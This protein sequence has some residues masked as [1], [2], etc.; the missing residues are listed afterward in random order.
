M[1]A[2]SGRCS[3]TAR[4]GGKVIARGSR[5]VRRGRATSVRVR[6]TRAGRARVRR[7]RAGRITLTIKAP[8]GGTQ[9]LR[10][11]LRR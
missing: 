3:V 5:R 10:I 8:G 9:R 1:G 4:L 2:T 6:L 7:A 11:T